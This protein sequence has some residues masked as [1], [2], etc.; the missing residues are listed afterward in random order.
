MVDTKKP[1]L[2]TRFP[3]I[4]STITAVIT[5]LFTL[6]YLEK[7]LGFF[8]LTGLT[9]MAVLFVLRIELWGFMGGLLV[10]FLIEAVTSGDQGHVQVLAILLVVGAFTSIGLSYWNDRVSETSTRRTSIGKNVLFAL[11]GV[12]ISAILLAFLISTT[13]RKIPTIEFLE[14]SDADWINTFLL[15]CIVGSFASPMFWSPFLASIRQVGL[16][17]IKLG[18]IIIHMIK[19]IIGASIVGSVVS[20]L[21]LG[22]SLCLPVMPEPALALL[23]STSSFAS[24]A[25]IYYLIYGLAW[26]Y[27]V[28]WGVSW[29][30]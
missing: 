16:R 24:I 19:G 26:L 9:V 22:F 4:I 2:A 5:Y 13:L 11:A 30:H 20:I 27:G 17:P 1:A 8:L 14:F 7:R 25:F 3:F 21:P 15:I 28:G 18:Q 23:D 10:A 12:G 6:V 29:G